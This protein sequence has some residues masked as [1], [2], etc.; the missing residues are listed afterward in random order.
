MSL[1]AW[2]LS[3]TVHEGGTGT[4]VPL[5]LHFRGLHR[6]GKLPLATGPLGQLAFP[7]IASY[8]G[9]VALGRKGR[10]YWGGVVD[11]FSCAEGREG[12]SGGALAGRKN[13]CRS[14]P[15]L[16]RLLLAAERIYV[17]VLI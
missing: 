7:L 1:G 9:E 16:L 4:E 14:A 3:P 5:P 13:S 8:R 12:V 2:E 6:L 11:N 10:D 15:M 17:C